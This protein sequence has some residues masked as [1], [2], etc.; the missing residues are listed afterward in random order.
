MAQH[1][2]RRGVCATKGGKQATGR[3]GE[4]TLHLGH[5]L[6]LFLSQISEAMSAAPFPSLSTAPRAGGDDGAM[7]INER[8]P[9]CC[10]V[11]ACVCAVNESEWQ[12]RNNTTLR[13]HKISIVQSAIGLQG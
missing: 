4:R 1:T 2:E 13:T 5:C 11:V 12:R 8:A 6:V 3:T 7:D 9:V 10:L